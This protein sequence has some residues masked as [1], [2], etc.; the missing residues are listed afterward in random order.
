MEKNEEMTRQ[1]ETIW[2][3]NNDPE[4]RAR[5]RAKQKKEERLKDKI[6]DLGL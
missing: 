2:R 5:K 6:E 3:E 1:M 4:L